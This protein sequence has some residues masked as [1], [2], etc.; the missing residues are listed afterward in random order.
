M[1]ED[2][3]PT[4][5]GLQIAD[6]PDAWRD[7]GFRVAADGGCDVGRVHLDLAG[8]DAGRGIVSWQ[9]QRRNERDPAA[10][11]PNG[12]RH[13]DHVVLVT[14]DPERT[15]GTL[16]DQGMVHRRTRLPDDYDQ[17][18]RQD[19]FRLGEVI[20]E[21]IGPREP[22]PA[23]VGRPDRLYGLAFT[24]DDLDATAAHLGERLG[25]VKD[26]VQPGRRI[27]TLRRGV[28]A[29]PLAFMSAGPG[30]LP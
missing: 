15:I 17:P 22:D 26:A 16:E 19:F 9:L 23:R 29:I 3:A 20:L 1:T 25:R 30:A 6:E 13:I 28:V 21:V 27:A 11:H 4:L 8:P 5:A 24:V 18:M 10:P 7:A 14:P 12:T 2:S